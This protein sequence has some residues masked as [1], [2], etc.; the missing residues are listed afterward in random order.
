M[1]WR[2]GR[3]GR[4]SSPER[5]PRY[6]SSPRLIA[7]GGGG[8]K[9]QRARYAGSGA[10]SYSVERASG[11]AGWGRGP[12]PRTA[13]PRWSETALP[14]RV[15]GRQPIHQPRKRNQLPHVRPSRDPCHR[16]FQPESE[17]RVGEGSIPPQIEIPGVCVLR[18]LLLPDPSQ[19]LVEIVFTLTPSDELTVSTHEQVVTTDGPRIVRILRRPRWFGM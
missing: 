5:R 2:P 10:P 8:G 16:T 11:S 4:F 3:A 18:K 6:Y 17:A 19:Q 14:P 9:P 15:A 13:A 7:G 12:G 1:G